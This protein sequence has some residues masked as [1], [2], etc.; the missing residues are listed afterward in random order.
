M[1]LDLQHWHKLQTPLALLGV[2]VLVA[3]L[4]FGLAKNYSAHQV[5]ALQIQQSLLNTA[6]ERY[7]SSGAEKD[8][9]TQYLPQYQELI[10]KGFVGEER[11]I[12]WVDELRAQHKSHKLFGIKYSI[13]QQE[14]YKPAFVPDPGGFVLHRSIMKLSLNML[15]EGDLLQLM[16][17]LGTKNYAPFMLRDCE[18]IRLNA[19]G[20]LGNQL[21][22]NLHAQC[23]LDWL[24]LR[25]PSPIQAP[26]IP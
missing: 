25:E 11:R 13:G 6:R 20:A 12:E 14:N 1:K 3:V 7:Q 24:T 18:I 15:H 2:V 22:A 5:K 17:A 16:E 4:L 8:T 19:G 21:V 26:L 9:I 23:E 10:S